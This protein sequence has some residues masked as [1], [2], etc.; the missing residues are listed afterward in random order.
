MF[1]I[2]HIARVTVDI[3]CR[4]I[5]YKTIEDDDDDDDD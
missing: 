5:I 1:N 4:M 3:M 2:D